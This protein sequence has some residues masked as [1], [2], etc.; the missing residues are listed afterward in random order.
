MKISLEIASDNWHAHENDHG[1][2][3]IGF[4]PTSSNIHA[5]QDCVVIV[6][7]DDEAGMGVQIAMSHASYRSFLLTIAKSRETIEAKQEEHGQ[8]VDEQ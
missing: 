1:F 2:K 7:A 8:D 3:F 6:F 5:N 4:Q